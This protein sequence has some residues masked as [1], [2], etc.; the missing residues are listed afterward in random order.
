MQPAELL[1]DLAAFEVPTIEEL[2]TEDFGLSDPMPLQRAIWRIADGRSLGDL[3][4]HP[5]VQAG[6]GTLT[7]KRYVP[8]TMSLLMAIRGA[9]SQTAAAVALRCALTCDLSKV[10]D[11]EMPRGTI[12]SLRKDAADVIMDHLVGAIRRSPRLRNR[13]AQPPTAGRVVLR[14]PTGRLVEIVVDAGKRAGGSLVSRW[15]FCLLA[16]EATRMVGAEEGVVN[17]DDSRAAVVGRLL[18]CAC[19]NE[20]LIGSPWA[21]F[22]PMYEIDREHFQKPG[23]DMVVVRARGDWL[24]PKHWT[25]AEI[26][27]A[28]A[29]P[30][31]Y[32]TSFLAEFVDPE[33]SLLSGD[34]LD[35]CVRKAGPLVLPTQLADGF[36]Y[37]AEMDP[38]TRLNA[39]TLAVARRDGKR[40]I[41][42]LVKQWMPPPSGE[43]SPAAV[44]REIRDLLAPYGVTR[45]GTD[46]WRADALRE[47]AREAAGLMLVDYT[48]SRENNNVGYLDL[49]MKVREKLVELPNDPIMLSDLRRIVRKTTQAG[50]AIQLPS[51]ADG[52]HCDYAPSIMRVVARDPRQPRKPDERPQA[53]VDQARYLARAQKAVRDRTKPGRGERRNPFGG[54]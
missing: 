51:T 21:P 26:D 1:D 40:S 44:L 54:W 23:P 16:D 14:H 45:I 41:V 27:K 10:T 4:S 32:K 38:A 42:V 3:A 46:Q 48:A 13:L 9:K 33:A 7:G 17:L 15:M 50:F 25:P 53:D 49:A 5:H 8:A 31:A 19:C 12:I 37:A 24:N 6:I 35:A 20:L 52:R 39:W 28:K 11:G 43:L 22:G 29:N 47:I 36:E 18:P 2:M 30:I 34:E